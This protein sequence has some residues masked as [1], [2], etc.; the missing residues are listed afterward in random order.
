[1]LWVTYVIPYPGLESLCAPQDVRREITCGVDAS[2]REINFNLEPCISYIY[3]YIHV[4]LQT[5]R[6]AGGGEA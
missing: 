1:V 2:F 5:S 4:I 6:G 3:I